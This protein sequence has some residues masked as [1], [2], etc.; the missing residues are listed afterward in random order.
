LI[1]ASGDGRALALL[2]ERLGE[3]FDISL[4]SDTDQAEIEERFSSLYIDARRK[5][6][7]SNNGLCLALAWTIELIQNYDSYW[8]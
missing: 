4:F 1:R 5:S 7:V 6:G 2:K 8:P 3:D